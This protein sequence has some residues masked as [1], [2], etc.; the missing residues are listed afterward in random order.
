[1]RDIASYNPGGGA[2]VVLGAHHFGRDPNDAIYQAV[3]NATWSR[4]LLVE[5]SPEQL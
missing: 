4:V 1:M 3:A 2:L 5:A